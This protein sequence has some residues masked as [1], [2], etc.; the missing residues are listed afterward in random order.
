MPV[1]I[2]QQ[3]DLEHFSLRG[4]EREETKDYRDNYYPNGYAREWAV[5]G[6]KNLPQ[7]AKRE[8]A[9]DVAVRELKFESKNI[10]RPSDR[11]LGRPCSDYNKRE[12][13]SY[14]RIDRRDTSCS[15][16]VAKNNGST[17]A[18]YGAELPALT[19]SDF[20]S[21]KTAYSKSGQIGVAWRKSSKTMTP[22]GTTTQPGTTKPEAP[23]TEIRE[24]EQLEPD[25]VE[26]SP[27]FGPHKGSKS[28]T[29]SL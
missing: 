28:T 6:K 18:V 29:E 5:C 14:R 17:P 4:D 10:I 21:G 2:I 23:N 1:H 22:N 12:N 11:R 26:L 20:T 8:T 24:H 7:Q 16:E 9:L 13:S 3:K 15:R 27:K 19:K 25:I